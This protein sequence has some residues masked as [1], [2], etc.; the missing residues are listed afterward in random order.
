MSGPDVPPTER[1]A[2][3]PL[4]GSIVAGKY[5]IEALLGSGAMGRV[6]RARQLALEKPV[7]IK[8]LNATLAVDPTFVARFAREAK[9]AAR[10]DHPNSIR[11][12][13]F[14]REPSGL[15]YI[16]MELVEGRDLAGEIEEQGP[17]APAR[18]VNILGQVLAALGVAHEMGV[19]HR[20]LKPA[21]VMLV[22]RKND[23]GHSVDLAKVCDFGIAKI[24]D[25]SEDPGGARPGG[26][27]P[28]TAGLVI[29]T[30]EYMA[31][32]Q[33]RG[34][35]I[36]AR[37]DIYAVG[38]IL[39][40]MLTGRL[41]FD[42]DTPLS[43]VI[44]HVTEEPARPSAVR[45]DVNPALEEI[46]MRALRKDPS[47]RFQNATDMRLA[48][49]ATVPQASTRPAARLSD[50]VSGPTFTPTAAAIEQVHSSQE[51]AR[52]APTLAGV[53]PPRASKPAT[54]SSRSWPLRA[55]VTLATAI[56]GIT[57]GSLYR[58]FEK[59]SQPPPQPPRV[60]ESAT[61]PSP[62]PSPTAAITAVPSVTAVAE[63]LRSHR[64]GPGLRQAAR[65]I[66]LR[67][68]ASQAP[69][70]RG[71]LF[72]ARPRPRAP[73]AL[74]L[75]S[76]ARR[77]RRPPPAR[78]HVR[79][80]VRARA[81]PR[82]RPRA[83]ARAPLRHLLSPR[84]PRVADPRDG[85]DGERRE[86]SAGQRR[87]PAHGLLPRRSAAALRRRRGRRNAAHR[88]GRRR[89]HHRRSLRR[90][91]R[92]GHPALRDVGGSRAQDSNVDTGS[93]SADIPLVYRPR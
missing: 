46:C 80:H 12:F 17:M 66:R 40:Q 24:V 27:H 30:P 16:A 29:G 36:D 78:A 26:T 79:A 47:E 23:D 82:A 84:P 71:A 51:E 10:L 75:A 73:R 44:K 76:P 77:R 54:Q 21:N 67:A 90:P 31:P 11:V 93:A 69:A 74:P 2:V 65:A 87:V 38:V 28:L 92:P 7:A 56:V 60:Q 86:P 1:P 61:M 13:D 8:V 68:P 91:A 32:E 22:K 88:N 52:H 3:D 63:S 35:K 58:H 34:A 70:N 50:R 72:E 53:T 85:R 64:R 37:A 9:A 19:L 5:A 89:D 15:F 59:N 49:A 20:D 57:V 41:P 55:G 81:R 18:I 45:P 42:G 6:F 48:L 14:G 33:A 83:R 62:A 25:R 43:M 39:Y 4:I